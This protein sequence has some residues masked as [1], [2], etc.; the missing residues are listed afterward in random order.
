MT[1]PVLLDRRTIAQIVVPVVADRHTDRGVRYA[2]QLAKAWS[3]PLVLVHIGSLD[4]SPTVDGKAHAGEDGAGVGRP[5]DVAEMSAEL[6]HRHPGLTI[7]SMAFDHD[8]IA[9]GINAAANDDSLVVLASDRAR[10]WFGADSIAERLVRLRQAPVV[11]LGPN[12]SDPHA[13]GGVII[14]LDGTPLA[15]DGIVPGIA[16][17][18][19]L[20]STAR[21]V[22]VIPPATVEH[23]EY[24]KSQGQHVSESAYL[25]AVSERFDDRARAQTAGGLPWQIIHGQ[26]SVGV[27]VDLATRRRAGLLVVT[28]HGGSGLPRQLFGSTSMGLVEQATVPILVVNPQ[29]PSVVSPS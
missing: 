24:L 18:A 23:I 29:G 26:D 11:M 22:S 21:V 3:I 17:A 5:S 1:S 20:G 16:F 9:E 10:Q 2:L 28:T 4:G 19:A 13:G 7:E 25:R 15:E 6:R 27:L 14:A 8:D 12:A